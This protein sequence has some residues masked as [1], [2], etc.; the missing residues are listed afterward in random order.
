MGVSYRRRKMVVGN[1]QV[2]VGNVLELSDAGSK[3]V[4]GHCVMFTGGRRTKEGPSGAC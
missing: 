1:I 2:T 3:S 4:L